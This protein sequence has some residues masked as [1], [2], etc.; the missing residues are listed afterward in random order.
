MSIPS[1][2]ASKRILLSMLSGAVMISFSGIWVKLAH[3]PPTA[4][5]FYR[6]LIGGLILLT[7]VVVKKEFRRRQRFHLLIGAI[8]G[9]A[10]ALDLYCYHLSIMLIGPGLA[11]IL[12]N[13]QV[14]ILSVIGIVFLGEAIRFKFVIA[15]PLAIA[16]L[17]C[18][19]GFEWGLLEHSYRIGI[20]LALATAAFYSAFILLLRK[21]QG[22]E[23]GHSV[24]YSLMLVS[25][26]C[27]VYL[28]VEMI[29]SGISFRIPDV[30]SGLSLVAL[31]LFSQTAGWILITNSLPKIRA[32]YA[33]LIL[34][35]QPALSFIWD[36]L[37][38]DR[39]TSLMNWMGVIVTLVAIYLGLTA[40]S[41]RS[42][43]PKI[44]MAK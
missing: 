36:V 38:F 20:Y 5:A 18:I 17:F 31:G 40:G 24:Y 10:F 4:S 15:V 23:S 26:M 29:V 2:F 32:S 34:L 41:K 3:V 44:K 14:F 16:G 8:C 39:A 21:L 12:S 9:L 13:F 22:A 28:A 11:T 19:I 37:F 35:L 43:Q 7:A 25:M 30:Q 1:G 33:G 27:A 6:V 42:G